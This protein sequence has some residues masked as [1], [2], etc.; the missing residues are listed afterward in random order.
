MRTNRYNKCAKSKGF[1]AFIAFRGAN[2][3]LHNQSSNA[4][5]AVGWHCAAKSRGMMPNCLKKSLEK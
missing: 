5:L 1:D 2:N 4:D 3:A